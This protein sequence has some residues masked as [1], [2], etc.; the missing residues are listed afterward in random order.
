MKPQLRRRLCSAALLL[1]ASLSLRAAEPFWFN[2]LVAHWTDYGTPEYLDFI[3]EAKP[4][5]AQ[6]GFYGV[7]FYSVA[8]TKFGKGYPAHFP[9]EGT[10][11]CGEFFRNLN[12]EVHARG[13]KV[14][15][16]FNT[17]FILGDPD[18][19]AG[20]FD[21][22]HNLW[23]TKALGPKPTPDPTQM[24]AVDA[25]GK[26]ITTTSYKI[27]GWPEYH[28]CLNNPLWRACLKPMITDAI[29]R[30]VDGLIANYYYRRDCMCRHCVGGFRAWLGTNYTAAQ[31][32]E[33]FAIENL[34]TH[35]FKEIPSWHNPKETSPYKLA[36]LKWTQISL[37]AAFDDVFIAHG[38]KLKPDLMVAQWNHLG[39]FNQIN[40]DERCLLPGDLWG[41]GE[42]YLWYSTGN[43]ASQ[44]DLANG[45]LGDGTLQLRYIRGAFGPKPFLLGKYEQTRTRATIA[46]GI[47]NGGAGLGFYATFKNP[48]GREAMTTYFGFAAKHRDLYV[49]A[50]PAAEL[51]LLY[52]R[53][54][55]HRGDVEPVARFKAIGKQLAREGYVFDVVPD[56][57]L[58]AEQLTKRPVVVTT[59]QGNSEALAAML[60]K[61][62]SQV[63]FLRGPAITLFTE[64]NNAE[65]QVAKWRK[66][67]AAVTRREGAPTVVASVLS[68]PK[69]RLVHL[70]NYNREEPPK[71]RTMGS[72]PH[73]ERPLAIEGTTV[74]L[75]LAPGERVK[76]IRL[77]SPD[78]EVSTGPAGLVQRTGEAAFTVP[79]LLIYTVAV[80]ELE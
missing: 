37:K 18:K 38:R 57:L 16:H 1:A 29:A 66:E 4:Q 6:V 74:R 17:T 54:A 41:R 63:R 73:E 21:W 68:Q 56:D 25:A 76:S 39:G 69:R 80:A 27:G 34:K 7:T 32:K 20:F 28:G 24:L 58:T 45:D 60:A 10:K 9:I 62:P 26:L 2:T 65:E 12:K 13:S 70:V 43:A 15:G 51:L 77:L 44:T 72:G 40:G 36:A 33:Q 49:G 52:P 48:A 30:G 31:L 79:R 46:E 22:Y 19:R 59:T 61:A 78:A 64:I 23:D 3:G 67:L 75:A 35:E 5:V 11:E 8:H 47:A 42:N 55:V 14:V 53:S 50:Q 71:T